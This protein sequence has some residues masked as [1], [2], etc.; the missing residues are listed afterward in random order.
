M[1]KFL[2]A[3]VGLCLSAT[4]WAAPVGSIKGYVQDP[5]GAAVPNASI[6]LKNEL[7]N[8]TAATKSDASGLYQFLDLAPGTYSVSVET[9]GFRKETV[10]AVEV[11]VDRIVSLDLKLTVGTV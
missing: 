4:L 7:T 6:Q 10:R 2:A 9:A 8:Q 1:T 3:V 5:S 11:V